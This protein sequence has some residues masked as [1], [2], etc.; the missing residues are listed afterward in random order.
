MRKLTTAYKVNRIAINYCRI[1][2][3]LAY[4]VLKGRILLF[5]KS[6]TNLSGPKLFVLARVYCIGLLIN[7]VGQTGQMSC[8]NIMSTV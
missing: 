7:L 1:R 5:H 6:F 3:E 4:P 8:D 2:L